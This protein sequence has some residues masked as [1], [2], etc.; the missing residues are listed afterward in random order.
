MGISHTWVSGRLEVLRSLAEFW[1][2]E[3]GDHRHPQ[4]R[5][6]LLALPRRWFPLLRA[7]AEIDATTDADREL[8]RRVDEHARTVPNS[9]IRQ[10]RTYWGVV[11]NP[12]TAEE[13]RR[14]IAETA[15]E[16]DR[17]GEHRP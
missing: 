9:V 5:G 15:N 11:V 16:L 10:G 17:L 13:L 1:G 4:L 3:G 6:A 7:W 12:D 8:Q 14:R 2:T